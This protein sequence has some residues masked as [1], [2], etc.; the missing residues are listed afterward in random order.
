MARQTKRLGQLIET[1][2]SSLLRELRTRRKS[3]ED[4]VLTMGDISYVEPGIQIGKNVFKMTPLATRQFCNHLGVP[5]SFMRKSPNEGEASKDAIFNYWRAR[6]H[7]TSVT[8][9]IRHDTNV[10]RA[11]L[12]GKYTPFDTIDVLPRMVEW[13]DT[14]GL[15]LHSSTDID[16]DVFHCRFVDEKSIALGSLKSGDPDVHTFGYHMRSSEVGAHSSID[17]MLL[18][19][20]Q[21]CSN[22]MIALQSMKPLMRLLHRSADSDTLQ[23]NLGKS[24]RLYVP[25]RNHLQSAIVAAQAHTFSNDNAAKQVVKGLLEDS[26]ASEV[27]VNRALAVYDCEPIASRF[28]VAQALTATARELLAADRLALETTAGNYITRSLAA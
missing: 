11:V 21:I 23:S 19:Y 6:K 14:L 13:A 12:P 17:A 3:L 1:D 4:M 5:H 25:Q 18:L 20:R 26:G 9:R 27:L 16:A 15:K 8:L 28:G 10:V 22:G 24:M 2:P 7:R